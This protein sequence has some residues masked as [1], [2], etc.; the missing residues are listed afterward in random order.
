MNMVVIGAGLA[1]LAAARRLH[2]AGVE[3]VVLEARD[4]VGGR[5]WSWELDNGEVVELGGEWIDSSQTTITDLAADLG[6][7]LVNGTGTI[8]SAIASGLRAADLLIA[9][10]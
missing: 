3:V 10:L 5:V 4:R 1:G 9:G 8:A 7:G 2:E 6:L